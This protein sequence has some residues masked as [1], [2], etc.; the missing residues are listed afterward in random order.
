MGDATVPGAVTKADANERTVAEYESLRAEIARRSTYQQGLLG[1]ELSAVTAVVVSAI[2]NAPTTRSV[3]VI[4]YRL[5]ML[6]PFLSFGLAA[7]W[8]DHHRVIGRLAL[9]IRDEIEQCPGFGW[10]T[11]SDR[12]RGK[13]EVDGPVVRRLFFVAYALVFIGPSCVIVAGAFASGVHT[14]GEKAATGIALAATALN[15]LLWASLIREPTRRR[16][17]ETPG[18]ITGPSASHR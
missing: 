7:L 14:S 2:S 10:E 6:L 18:H 8:I 16:P 5:V 11:H 12:R 3:W 9:Y 13:G 15:M 4:D 17:A 1:L